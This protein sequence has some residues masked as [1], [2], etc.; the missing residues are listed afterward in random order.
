MEEGDRQRG[1]IVECNSGERTEKQKEKNKAR[2]K[3]LREKVKYGRG[4][5]NAREEW[6]TSPKKG[7]KKESR[8]CKELINKNYPMLRLSHV[9]YVF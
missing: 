9:V 4:E 3:I 2:E 7:H 1:V 8:K 5:N 6:V